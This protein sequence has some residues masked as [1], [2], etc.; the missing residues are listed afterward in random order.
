M[1]SGI[2]KPCLRA[3]RELPL[4]SRPLLAPCSLV[5]GMG[6]AA[7]VLVWIVVLVVRVVPV[8]WP[9][10]SRTMTPGQKCEQNEGYA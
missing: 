2:K 6:A 10:M 3:A 8:D 7:P 5:V 9:V 4:L 1:G